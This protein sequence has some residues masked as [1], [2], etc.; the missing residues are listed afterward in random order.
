MYIKSSDTTLSNKVLNKL[1]F[2]HSS[3][4][5]I[6]KLHS[7][8]IR[9]SYWKNFEWSSSLL[10]LECCVHIW[11]LM[12]KPGQFFKDYGLLLKHS[13]KRGTDFNVSY[14]RITTLNIVKANLSWIKSDNSDL[15]ILWNENLVN[16]SFVG[17]L[18]WERTEKRD[19]LFA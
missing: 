10:A 12:W 14:P 9:R 17:I 4:F 3:V 11:L 2:R 6:Y 7:Q 5:N 15:F 13:C 19:C 1:W 16:F 18:Q 8:A